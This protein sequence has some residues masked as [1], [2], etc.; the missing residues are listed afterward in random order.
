MKII[1]CIKQVPATSK[2]ELDPDD[3]TLRRQDIERKTNANDLFAIETALRLREAAGGSVTAVTMGPP[4][5]EEALRD[6]LT[7]GVDEC[8]LLCDKR[9]AG[10]DVLATGYTL[11]Q[12]IR[13]LGGF[14][15]IL[16]GKQTTDGDT[17]QV[18]PAL[19]EHLNIPHVAWAHSLTPIPGGLR[20][21][22]DLSTIT[23]VSEMALPCLITVAPNLCVPRL[24][25][26]RLHKAIEGR[27]VRLVTHSDLPDKSLTRYGIKGS[28]TTVVR[29]FPPE[30]AGT[31][32]ILCGDKAAALYDILM[33]KKFISGG[34]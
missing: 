34:N 5:A 11:S 31:R 21:T 14:D 6:A 17:S 19:A 9:F 32:Q 33:E 29:T 27:P 16:C 18:G 15:L 20:V 3:G 25:S 30:I 23:Q 24:P 12:G 22:H 4:Q 7:M 8:V 2:V 10:A 28:P 26:Y 1:V 13:L